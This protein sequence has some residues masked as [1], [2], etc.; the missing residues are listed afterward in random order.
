MICDMTKSTEFASEL[1][2]RAEARNSEYQERYIKTRNR[3]R[4]CLHG[5][6]TCARI[7]ETDKNPNYN[8]Q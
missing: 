6:G 8:K 1:R 4:A 3:N 5:L 7:T 2:R